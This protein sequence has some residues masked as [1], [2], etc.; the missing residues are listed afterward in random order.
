MWN[1]GMFVVIGAALA[2]NR[3]VAQPYQSV[4]V[5]HTLPGWQCMLL[6]SEYG[7]TGAYAQSAPAYT[8]PDKGAP[9]SG[10]EN[11][12]IIASRPLRPVNGRTETIAPNGRHL[13]IDV[14]LL[15][16]W[17]SVSEP[18]AV[19]RPALLSNG[20]YGWSTDNGK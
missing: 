3:L 18:K 16:P 6:A 14:N 17:R 1:F 9:Q 11:G 15:A 7:P 5:L 2:S 12:V 4:T 8:G 10:G 20:M 13:W 19:C